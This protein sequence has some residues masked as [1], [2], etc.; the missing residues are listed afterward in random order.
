MNKRGIDMSIQTIIIVIIA[1]IVLFVVTMF[2][3]GGFKNLSQQFGRFHGEAL[4]GTEEAGEEVG[5]YI[6]GGDIFG[7]TSIKPMIVNIGPDIR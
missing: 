2:F 1:L 4:S 3:T 5:D 7:K 6:E